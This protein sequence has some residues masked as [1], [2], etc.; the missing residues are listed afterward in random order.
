MDRPTVLGGGLYRRYFSGLQTIG[1]LISGDLS[2]SR[3]RFKAFRS[4]S[5]RVFSTAFEF[6]WTKETGLA[7]GTSGVVAVDMLI[8]Y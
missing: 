2:A 4:V 1:M 6:F 7:T 5:L 3:F 8:D